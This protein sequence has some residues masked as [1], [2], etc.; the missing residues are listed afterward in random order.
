MRL[1]TFLALILFV[2]SC[3]EQTPKTPETAATPEPME[4]KTT[5]YPD[6]L[7]GIF[8]AHGGLAAWKEQRTLEFTLPK[9]ENPETHTIDLL[10]RKER[11]Q[12]P[13]YTVGHDGQPWVLE[14]DGKY[15]SNPEFYHNLMFYFYAMPFV[16][17]DKG[18]NYDIAEDLVVDGVAYPGIRISYDMG[19]GVSPKDE[20]FLHYDAKTNQMAWLGYTVTYRSGEV[21][22]KVNWIGY[23]EWE[24]L[25]G[26][27]L[28]KAISWHAHEGRDIKEKVNT[29]VFENRSLSTEARPSTFY[30]KPETGT[31]WEKPSE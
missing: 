14:Q 12:T 8:E 17:A 29:L 10:T 7:N 2:F 27:V 3:K 25:N 15:E 18:I 22:D 5:L 13:A 1:F 9:P 24:A 28:P 20:Y 19:V 26:V 30:D 23:H 21:S 31:Y 6:A 4:K 16:L 11:I